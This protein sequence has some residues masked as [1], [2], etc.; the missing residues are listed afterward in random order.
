MPAPDGDPRDGRPDV[1]VL[2]FLGGAG[3]VTGS[4]FLVETPKARV[5][6][7][8][9]LYQG[10]KEL[11]L[12]NWARF[13]VDPASID[14]VVLTHAHVDHSGA[15]PLLVAQGFAGPVFSSANTAALAGVVLPDSGHLQEEEAA[16]ANR[17]GF[18]KHKPALPLYTEDQARRSLESF[19]PVEFGHAV[20]V[21]DGVTVTLRPAGHILGSSVVT[22]D[23]DVDGGR[24][25]TFSGDLG[26]ARHPLL[27]PPAPI[28]TT[29]VVLVEST[30]GNRSHDDAG[31]REAFAAAIRET[32][33]R[34]GVVVIPA[35]AVDRTEVLLMHLKSLR[36]GGE[37]PD[38]PVYVD[39]PMALA[40]L[41]IYRD[42]VAD[43]DP[44]IRP[45]VAAMPDPFDM[46]HV[47]ATRDVEQSME[48]DQLTA[49]AIIVSASGMATGG[50]VLHHLRRYLPDER[51]SVVLVGYQAQQTRGRQL[52]DGAKQLK[53]L[54]HY[55]SVHA[56][57]VN[58]PAF[59][60]HADQDELMGWLE[61]AD[62]APEAAYVIHGEPESAEHLCRAI[63]H[64]L[65][66]NAV[67]PTLGEKVRVDRR[68][69]GD[70]GGVQPPATARHVVPGEPGNGRPVTL[71]E[72]L[73]AGPDRAVAALP[74]DDPERVARLETEVAMGF[75]MLAG[76][77]RAVSV[78]GSSRTPPDS[79]E[80]DLARRTAAAI[81]RRGFTIV[82]GG[83]PGSME[84]ANRG[85]RDA[86][87]LSVGLGIEL[88]E[89]QRING[90][91]D[92]AIEFKHFFVRKLMFVRYASAFVVL[93]GGL[94]TLDELFEAH[95]LIQTGKVRQFPVVLVGSSFWRGLLD[96]ERDQLV[97][98]DK[99]TPET[100]DLLHVADDPE[101]VAA[102]V[103]AAAGASP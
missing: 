6:V 67:V 91:V 64:R 61:T 48:L 29:D 24:R 44:E 35:F 47:R 69:G 30:Y 80:Y 92:L 42:A 57:V 31:A 54:G 21:A 22:M 82:T 23:L 60:V 58:L 88:P 63:G 20:G 95:T 87:A 39:S 25:L 73:L 93:P 10:L 51:A 96:W 84:A 46:G 16:Y 85:A 4:K 86:G 94:G 70:G 45:E 56:D 49:P 76:I 103:E 14:A 98:G 50:R 72:E 12:R 75:G 66:W 27:V 83:G 53:L 40:A 1:P 36:D 52:A 38:L 74:G 26:R 34:G 77:G 71:D 5:L 9:G 18:S 79:A 81:G 7:D 78:F 28:G 33:G 32:A 15:I 90:Y 3:T 41:E 68:P 65:G 62:T 43:R 89:E 19:R 101:E 55:L 97:G 2:S 59:S 102:I 13:P 8:C 17:R 100:L 99:I 37:I 11:R